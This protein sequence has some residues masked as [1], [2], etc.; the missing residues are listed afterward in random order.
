MLEKDGRHP[1]LGVLLLSLLPRLECQ[2]CQKE[3]VSDY[4]TAAFGRLM[5]IS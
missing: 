1:L 4:S 2:N 5:S 3:T